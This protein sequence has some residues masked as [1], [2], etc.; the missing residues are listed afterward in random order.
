MQENKIV[1]FSEIARYSEFCVQQGRLD[2]FHLLFQTFP[3]YL[4]KDNSSVDLSINLQ[5]AIFCH[6]YVCG[7]HVPCTIPKITEQLL[8]QRW[9]DL[10]IDTLAPFSSLLGLCCRIEK[11]GEIQNA[12]TKQVFYINSKYRS[13]I[14][15]TFDWQLVF[16]I[17]M[18]II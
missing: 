15:I 12:M 18:Q 9:T 2:L 14:N 3:I 11:Y 10:E 8:V 4:G 5:V 6:F 17:N 13:I 1:Y 16:T 7:T